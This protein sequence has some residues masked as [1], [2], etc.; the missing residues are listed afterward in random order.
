MAV[1]EK[2]FTFFNEKWEKGNTPIMGAADHATWLGTLVFDGA[3][4]VESRR[5][6]AGAS[7]SRTATLAAKDAAAER[8]RAC[9][10]GQA[11]GHGE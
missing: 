1:G 7:F 11:H 2:I 5:S 10:R 3:R 9:P 4:M 6:I 8:R